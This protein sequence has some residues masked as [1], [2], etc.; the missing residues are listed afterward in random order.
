MLFVTLAAMAMTASRAGVVLSLLMLVLAFA[1]FFHRD[2][3]RSGRVVAS[4]AALTVGAFVLLQII[5]TGV[6]NRFDTEGFAGGGRL[7][8]YRSTIEMIADHPWFGT[9]LGTFPWGF[10]AYRSADISLWG[11]WTRAHNTLLEI[12]AELGIPLAILVVTGWIIAFAVLIHGAF[13]RRRSL[14]TPVAGLCVG[15]LGVLHSL[16]DFSLQIPGYAIGAFALIGAGL[17]QSLRTPQPE[18]GNSGHTG[19][20]RSRFTGKPRQV[21]ARE[22]SHSAG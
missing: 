13:T 19:V 15:G 18:G 16:V 1:V 5:G 12:A 22:L 3:A 4:V 20:R 14:I 11:T 9:G 7:G 8:G 6:T 21:S 2:L 17:A 10:P